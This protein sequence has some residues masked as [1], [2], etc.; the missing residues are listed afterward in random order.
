MERVNEYQSYFWDNLTEGF[1]SGFV[2]DLNG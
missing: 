1:F 2:R